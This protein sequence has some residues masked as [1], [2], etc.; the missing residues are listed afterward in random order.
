MTLQGVMNRLAHC[1]YDVSLTFPKEEIFGITSQ[2]RR[3][4]LSIVLN[5]TEGYARKRKAVF[6]N[7]IEISYGS[8]K[9]TKYI[10]EFSYKRK[11]MLEKDWVELDKL[12]DQVGRMLWGIMKKLD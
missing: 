4:V 10:L 5:Y 1:V 3:A 2:L 9:E 6:K 11:Y 8:L 12:C 7:F